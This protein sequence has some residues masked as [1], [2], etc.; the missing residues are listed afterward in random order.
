[1]NVSAPSRQPKNRLWIK[2]VA[3]A[4]RRCRHVQ[5]V[6]QNSHRAGRAG[7]ILNFTHIGTI[8]GGNG[9]VLAYQQSPMRA[10]DN[11]SVDVPK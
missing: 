7:P 11:S 10:P 5:L 8:H 2:L 4:P 3:L 6:A 9:L 1:M